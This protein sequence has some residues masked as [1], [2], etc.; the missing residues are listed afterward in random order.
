MN[1]VTASTLVFSSWTEELKVTSRVQKNTDLLGMC[2]LMLAHLI[3]AEDL[4]RSSEVAKMIDSCLPGSDRGFWLLPM[5]DFVGWVVQHNQTLED[6]DFPQFN[7]VKNCLLWIDIK[8]PNPPFLAVSHRW[9]GRGRADTIRNQHQKAIWSYR[10]RF[11]F[12]WVDRCCTPQD[13]RN[14]LM[15]K[16]LTPEI[17]LRSAQVLS[18]DSDDGSYTT[19]LW[20]L[21]E[22]LSG[23]RFGFYRVTG[24]FVTYKPQTHLLT[25]STPSDAKVI[26]P[27]ILLALIRKRAT[28][29]GL[30]FI[31][32]KS[33]CRVLM[34]RYKDLKE[35]DDHESWLKFCHVSFAEK[36]GEVVGHGVSDAVTSY[37]PNATIRSN[38]LKL[39]GGF[40]RTGL[41]DTLW[42]L[43][44]LFDISI[45]ILYIINLC[46]LNV[47]T[48]KFADSLLGCHGA[49]DSCAYSRDSCE[50]LKE[51]ITKLTIM[52]SIPGVITSS[53]SLFV[54]LL[55]FP[56]PL[57][58]HRTKVLFMSQLPS[59][60]LLGQEL[61]ITSFYGINTFSVIGYMLVC[62][63]IAR[64]IQQNVRIM[65]L[66]HQNWTAA[67]Q[68]VMF[69]PSLLAMVL[70]PGRQHTDAII[71]LL[72]SIIFLTLMSPFMV[73]NVLVHLFDVNSAYTITRNSLP[74]HL[75]SSSFIDNR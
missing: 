61:T 37:T 24:D 39:N 47:S 28:G 59:V 50:D 3:Q 69:L 45:W 25:C 65:T 29:S 21:L 63:M 30:D 42:F 19:S 2:S 49:C 18:M 52:Y 54:R 12:L 46:T 31:E 33:W 48:Q 35:G 67:D 13:E 10:K 41:G 51:A 43:G 5:Q 7:E 23:G 27:M 20:C 72:W 11:K 57:G 62:V 56:T 1:N 64:A 44:S 17:F 38:H 40:K 9:T 22:Q 8:D 66:I 75:F 14:Q 68:I 34:G 4:S 53:I 58:L 60:V 6:W 15:S 74:K 70:I 36:S 26:I 16:I 71:L 55:D 32:L 73:I